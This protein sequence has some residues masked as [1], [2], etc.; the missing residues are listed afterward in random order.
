MIETVLNW[1]TVQ[2]GLATD[3]FA[4]IPRLLDAVACDALIAGYG[5][6]ARYRNTV[7]MERHNFGRGEYRYFAY[8]LPG[9]IAGLRA[10]LYRGLAPMA[11]EWNAATRTAER[12]P[13]ELDEYLVACAAAGQRRPTPLI[14]RYREGDYNALHQDLYGERA[15][16]LQATVYL[17]D[18]SAYAGGETILA[19]Q[20]PRAQTVAR[21]LTFE[22][23]DALV[24]PNRYRPVR[25]TNGTFHRENVRHGISTL[26]RG[27]RYALGL[28][29]HDAR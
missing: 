25:G 26:E 1:T 15:F 14:L 13:A 6:D 12:Y 17:S 19:F 22:R 27:E 21:A 7:T 2:S 24:F 5:D 20:R 10:M 8:P 23:G 16:P 29:F 28:I 3:G 9:E 4:R 18:R 11:N